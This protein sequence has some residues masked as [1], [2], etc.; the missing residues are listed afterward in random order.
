MLITREMLQEFTKV[1][2]DDTEVQADLQ[3]CYIGSAQQVINDYVGYDVETAAEFD[4][5]STETDESTGE[6]TEVTTHEIPQIFRFVCLEI[7]ALMQMEEG[8]NLGYSSS[9][10]SGGI[11]RTFLNVTKYDAYLSRLSSFRRQGKLEV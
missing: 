2:P 10:D 11:G 4:R 5:V 9:S 1:R 3:D 8:S 6:E 7:A